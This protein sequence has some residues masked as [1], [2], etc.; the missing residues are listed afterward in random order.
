[1]SVRLPKSCSGH[2]AVVFRL[3]R[4]RT[5][6][7]IFAREEWGELW[8]LRLI[9]LGSASG[10]VL[11]Y[12]LLRRLGSLSISLFLTVESKPVHC[13]CVH[14]VRGS[15]PEAER[16]LSHESRPAEKLGNQAPRGH[17]SR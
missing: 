11:G 4:N 16:G 12:A 17:T 14:L 2:R 8:D 10:M 5:V 13:A 6:L 7:C 3:E 15:S 9:S 1:M